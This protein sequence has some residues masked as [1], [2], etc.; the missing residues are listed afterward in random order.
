MFT[1]SFAWILEHSKWSLTVVQLLVAEV[2]TGFLYF[3]FF[4][5]LSPSSL[6]TS[7]LLFLD[8]G[9]QIAHDTTIMFLLPR[10]LASVLLTLLSCSLPCQIFISM[11]IWAG[12]N[13]FHFQEYYFEL[14]PSDFRLI[15]LCS[16]K[17]KFLKVIIWADLLCRRKCLP[18]TSDFSLPLCLPH[19]LCYP[20]ASSPSSKSSSSQWELRICFLLHH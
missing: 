8:K 20:T 6:L 10:D 4:C 1:I 2:V 19:L 3:I 12:W 18:S 5:S 15:T 7:K 11:S 9:S 13:I 17:A 14:P 16:V